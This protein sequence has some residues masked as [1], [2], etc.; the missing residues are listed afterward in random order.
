MADIQNGYLIAKGLIE[1]Q[2]D[3]VL[4]VSR[5]TDPE[6]KADLIA[7]IE[8]LSLPP[9][10]IQREFDKNG[11]LKSPKIPRPDRIKEITYNALVRLALQES[12]PPP[13]QPPEPEK[14]NDVGEWMLAALLVNLLFPG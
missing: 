7:F 13:I 11:R 3:P 10:P 1:H 6:Q 9:I 5:M 14:P 12:T 8:S 2:I 4:A